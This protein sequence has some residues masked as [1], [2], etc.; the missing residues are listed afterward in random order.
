MN[1]QHRYTGPELGELLEQV[2]RELGV[3]ATIHEANKIRTG[4]LA[5]F[6]T[7]EVFEVVASQAEPMDIGSFDDVFDYPDSGDFGGGVEVGPIRAT[8]PGRGPSGGIG[9]A[10]LER[11][12]AISVQERI[13]L[14]RPRESVAVDLRSTAGD[15]QFGSHLRRELEDSR[16]WSS[17]TPPDFWHLLR[18]YEKRA[19]AREV[20]SEVVAV[21]GNLESAVGLGKRLCRHGMADDRELVALTPNKDALGLPPWRITSSG[22]DLAERL[23]Y[24]SVYE[25]KAVVVLDVAI[26]D[27]ITTEFDR[28]RRAGC[29]V[30]H[31][32][33]DQ[34]LSARKVFAMLQEIGGNAV[35]DVM[36]EADPGYLLG[37][38]ARSVPLVSVAGRKVDAAF[39]MALSAHAADE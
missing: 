37:L 9:A 30:V 12:E 20:D 16:R 39:L 36:H 8:M 29:G 14:S 28:I 32:A 31:L 27:A 18:S 21:V 11:A 6:F 17:S 2:R 1:Q 22:K 24:W 33:L 25:R 10:L 23:E 35:V 4:G 3:E 7:T 13:Q 15:Q 19:A 26:G 38:V 34:S 5:G